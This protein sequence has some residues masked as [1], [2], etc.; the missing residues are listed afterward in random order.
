MN[1]ADDLE[2]TT[3]DADDSGSVTVTVSGEIDVNTCGQLQDALVALEGKH[4]ALDLDQVGFIDSSGLRSV[5]TGQRRITDAGGSLRV[6]A[7][8]A[9]AR[10]LFEIT[11]LLEMFQVPES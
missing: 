6:S 11:G 3:T 1:N 10:R 7:L 8:S 5:I 9:P 4:V 2:I